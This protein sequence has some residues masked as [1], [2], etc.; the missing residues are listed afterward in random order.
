MTGNSQCV[1]LLSGLHVIKLDA[2]VLSQA[3]RVDGTVIYAEQEPVVGLSNSR[4]PRHFEIFEG[5]RRSASGG[6]TTENTVELYTTNYP[7]HSKSSE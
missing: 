5:G 7:K 6:R 2:A 3:A 1:Y 4:N